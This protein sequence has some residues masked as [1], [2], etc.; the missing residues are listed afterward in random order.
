MTTY[1]MGESAEAE[2]LAMVG[3]TVEDMSHYEEQVIQQAERSTAPLLTSNNSS[4]SRNGGVATLG[5]RG[6]VHAL[7]P[8]YSHRKTGKAS[9]SNPADVTHFQTVLARTRK[10]LK[11]LNDE[12]HRSQILRIK[13]Q[14]ILV[15]LSEKLIKDDVPVQIAREIAAEHQRIY[16]IQ[17]HTG[18]TSDAADDVRP[19]ADTRSALSNKPLGEVSVD[20]QQESE[21]K[22]KRRRLQAW[23]SQQQQETMTSTTSNKEADMERSHILKQKRKERQERRRKRL[24]QLLRINDA[25]DDNDLEDEVE[26]DDETNS[27]MPARQN[28]LSDDEQ[29]TQ[30]FGDA[31]DE[32]NPKVG[33]ALRP[34]QEQ[35][36]LKVDCPLC[37]QPV[38]YNSGDVPDAVL[39]I[40]IDQCQ[41]SGRRLRRR[42]TTYAEMDTVD[43]DDH[44][45]DAKPPR[46]RSSTRRNSST[47]KKAKKELP[48]IPAVSSALD[49]LEEWVYEDRVDDWIENGLS[50]MKKMAE[51]D[52]DEVAPGAVV[53]SDRLH[54]PAWVNNRLFPYQRLGVQ[55]M[56]ELHQQEAGGIVGDEM[57]LGKTV[58]VCSFLGCMAASR[59]LKSVLI[60]CPATMLRHWL[61]ELAVWAPGLRRILVHKSGETDG[62]SRILSGSLLK[63]MNQW[64]KNARAD[65]LYEPIDEQ[66]F[67]EN[68]EDSFVGTGYTFVTSYE[69][70]RRFPDLWT[71][72]RWSYV[73]LDEGQKIRNPDSDI[74]LVCKRLRTPHRLLL[75]GTPIQNDLKELW[76]L[77]DFVFPGRL[78]TLPAFETEFA[79]PIKR[80]GF[81][82]ASPMQVQL[83]YRCALVLK[84]LINPYLL[85]RQKKDIE[86]VSRMP[87]KTEQVLFCRLSK[88]QRKLLKITFKVMSGFSEIVDSGDSDDDDSDVDNVESVVERSGKLEVLAKILPLWKKQGHRVL[89]FCQ[90]TKMLNILQRFVMAN[91]WKF[92]RMDGKT[93][94]SSRQTLVDAFNEDESY[95]ILLMTTRTGGVGVN[96]TGANRVI[97]Y[98]PDW[99]PQTDSQA[100]A[101][102]HRFGQTKPVTIYRL[103]TA[104]TIE[105]KIYHRQIFKTALT[106]RV[107]QDPKQKRLFSQRDLQDLFTL[108]ADDGSVIRGGQGVTELGTITKGQGVVDP[109]AVASRNK[110]DD[111]DD[112]DDMATLETVMKSKG[113]AGVFDH[114]FVDTSDVKKSLAVREMEEK[115]KQVAAEAIKALQASAANKRDQFEPTYTGSEETAS[116]RFGHGGMLARMPNSSFG[117]QGSGN[118]FAGAGINRRDSNG[119]PSSKNLLAS[120]KGMAQSSSGGVVDPETSR[121]AALLQRI[122]TY[123]QRNVYRGGPT[124]DDVLKEFGDVPPSD[125][126]IFRRL[127]NSVA[128]VD[129]GRWSLKDME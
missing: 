19:K 70:L 74:T 75:S 43:D 37:F 127:L 41:K 67:I 64:L 60:V 38:P 2:L 71:S 15:Y 101:R 28:L 8:S 57:G 94:V 77:F 32:F 40:H 48:S 13:E 76:T 124:T 116:G 25:S 14:L 10:E 20:Q 99:N 98:D 56:W 59:L 30:Q 92:G 107:L 23:K 125:A 36:Q 90:W 42:P 22:R 58:Q 5:F 61:Q 73:V 1:E 44:Y 11:E 9:S 103:I 31:Y 17:N 33:V 6:L 4:N 113:L 29:E 114:D 55:W 3:G 35:P 68:D 96:L 88:V 111:D 18:V 45:L 123:I 89:I 65:R 126:S 54:I 80:G 112:N 52:S 128:K 26:F 129:R 46:T 47:P 39:S 121:Y 108:K 120:L 102:S 109:E 27:K 63:S 66:D 72:H 87:G 50:K 16:Q 122:Q 104:G 117:R 93:S 110:V 79:E 100:R 115:A 81:S 86:E 62:A 84:D 119:A 95:F 78:G 69:N 53:Y 85:R 118:N 49:D 83:A 12:S 82:N 7:A 51:R 106:N 21:P 34:R 105:E 24:A 91:G 97:I